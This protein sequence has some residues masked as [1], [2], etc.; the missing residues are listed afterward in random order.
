MLVVSCSCWVY[1][2]VVVVTLDYRVDVCWWW[3]FWGGF[4]V[5][6]LW[7]L[8]LVWRRFHGDFVLH[9]LRV[10]VWGCLSGIPIALVMGAGAECSRFGCGV[11]YVGELAVC[12]GF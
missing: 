8:V 1:V 6:L 5:G 9:S 3:L 2:G 7:C 10:R 12:C 4:C 11:L